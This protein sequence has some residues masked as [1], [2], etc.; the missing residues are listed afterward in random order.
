MG[1]DNWFSLQLNLSSS[2]NNGLFQLS[3]PMKFVPSR[4]REEGRYLK[5]ALNLCE[6]SRD[7]EVYIFATSYF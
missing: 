5:K 3:L 6:M 4:D 1:Q 2:Y 7:G